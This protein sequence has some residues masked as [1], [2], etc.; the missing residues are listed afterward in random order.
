MTHRI[1][2]K[3]SAR[4][5]TSMYVSMNLFLQWRVI[6]ESAGHSDITKWPADC[7]MYYTMCAFKYE[8]VHSANRLVMSVSTPGIPTTATPSVPP[9]TTAIGTTTPVVGEYSD[10]VTLPPD[11]GGLPGHIRCGG[12]RRSS[13]SPRPPCDDTPSASVWQTPGPPC[14]YPSDRTPPDAT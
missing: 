4:I 3:N 2:S 10:Y 13:A 1:R 8:R 12:I 6:F 14:P 11:H 9:V 7:T 5:S